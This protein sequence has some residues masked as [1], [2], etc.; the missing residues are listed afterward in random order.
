MHYNLV[1]TNLMNLYIC[2]FILLKCI[3]INQHNVYVDHILY[4]LIFV[5]NIKYNN[6]T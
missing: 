2:I 6:I 4:S 3:K 1:L 5:L